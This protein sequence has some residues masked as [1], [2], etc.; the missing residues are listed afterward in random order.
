ML[1]GKKHDPEG[2]Y[3]K[4]WLPELQA[5][6]E[7]FIHSPWRMPQQMQQQV[8]CVIGKDYPRPIVDHKVARERAL[9]AYGE[10]RNEHLKIGD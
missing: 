9:L 5:V 10:A 8:G 2:R 3:V 4:R 6:P 1:Q 7:R